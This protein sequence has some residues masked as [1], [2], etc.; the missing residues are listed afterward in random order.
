MTSENEYLQRPEISESMTQIINTGLLDFKGQLGTY[1]KDL[2]LNEDIPDEM[3]ETVEGIEAESEG[4]LQRYA[5]YLLGCFNVIREK[6]LEHESDIASDNVVVMNLKLRLHQANEEKFRS[7]QQMDI[8]KGQ[9]ERREKL[10]GEQRAMFYKQLLIMKEQLYQKSRIGEAYQADPT[11]VF[12]PEAWIDGINQTN[13]IESE[14]MQKK[15]IKE[16]Q[17]KMMAKWNDEKKKLEAQIKLLERDRQSRLAEQDRKHR[18]ELARLTE[19]LE[20]L[21][22]ERDSQVQAMMTQHQKELEAIKTQL[23]GVEEKMRKEKEEA[24]TDA[25]NEFHMR[26][27]KETRE[28]REEAAALKKKASDLVLEGEE[29]KRRIEAMKKEMGALEVAQAARQQEIKDL[30]REKEEL[31]EEVLQ[32]KAQDSL[33]NSQIAELTARLESAE[34]EKEGEIQRNKEHIKDLEEKITMSEQRM[35]KVNDELSTT[36]EKIKNKELEILAVQHELNQ[37]LGEKAREIED[38]KMELNNLS[39]QNRTA[40]I[41]QQEDAEKKWKAKET[42]LLMKL[43]R[44]ETREEYLKSQEEELE[45]LKALEMAGKLENGKVSASKMDGLTSIAQAVTKEKQLKQQRSQNNWELLVMGLLNQQKRERRTEVIKEWESGGFEGENDDEDEYGNGSGNNGARQQSQNGNSNEE[46]GNGVDGDNDHDHDRDHDRDRDR[47]GEGE[48]DDDFAGTG[49]VRSR[50][51][52][53][54]G[55]EEAQSGQPADSD[56]ELYGDDRGNASDE[57]REDINKQDEKRISKLNAQ[58]ESKKC[59]RRRRR[60]SGFLSRVERQEKEREKQLRDLRALI[61]EERRRNL[62]KVL[63][64]ACLLVDSES[65]SLSGNGIHSGG[66]SDSEG[67]SET[68]REYD[69]PFKTHP[70]GSGGHIGVVDIG[71]NREYSAGDWRR[72]D[73]DRERGGFTMNGGETERQRASYRVGGTDGVVEGLDVAVTTHDPT[74]RRSSPMRLSSAGVARR[75]RNSE[76]DIDSYLSRSLMLPPSAT[77][78]QIPL[79]NLSSTYS[80]SVTSASSSSQYIP[81]I[82]APSSSASSSSSGVVMSSPFVPHSSGAVTDRYSAQG[83]RPTPRSML[84]Q[85]RD[86]KRGRARDMSDPLLS[87]LTHSTSFSSPSSTFSSTSNSSSSSASASSKAMDATRKMTTPPPAVGAAFASASLGDNENGRE[88]AGTMGNASFSKKAPEIPTLP[89]SAAAV[90]ES[91]NSSAPTYSSRLIDLTGDLSLPTT[92]KQGG[93]KNRRAPLAQRETDRDFAASLFSRNSAAESSRSRES[94]AS[95]GHPALQSRQLPSFEGIVSGAP[96]S[97]TVISDQDTYYSEAKPVKHGRYYASNI[98]HS[99]GRPAR[100][101]STP[102]AASASAGSSTSSAS[103]SPFA[104]ASSNSLASSSTSPAAANGTTFT[105]LRTSTFLPPLSPT[106]ESSEN[107]LNTPSYHSSSTDRDTSVSQRTRSEPRFLS[108]SRAQMVSEKT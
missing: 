17:D 107:Q 38:L 46:N 97:S 105:A 106:P 81:A 54:G 16:M 73:I 39:L 34:R 26:L 64:A 47:D 43:Q 79:M 69:S 40:M 22:E 83:S 58:Q 98:F 71:T 57:E 8:L 20:R 55:D 59:R 1:F 94:K 85:S 78:N 11:D 28:L 52:R 42:E 75:M 87:T 24:I 62:E 100:K 70:L 3:Q 31:K 19:Q 49:D 53:F 88:A 35:K 21:S 2:R 5:D 74:Q 7:N 89:L 29:L 15:K 51:F 27:E 65:F 68:L 63:D 23:A 30:R 13:E 33:K 66:A 77:S 82:I 25:M 92:P 102:A 4:T 95:S 41:R 9:L 93:E 50:S 76:S 14:E 84:Q 103:T 99:P 61:E 18:D 32:T 101:Q 12:Q 91:A 96:S 104:A 37:K 86:G 48:G 80:S 72:R 56:G 90:M 60:F 6:A 108:H 10:L 45:R 67:G 36:R 44:F